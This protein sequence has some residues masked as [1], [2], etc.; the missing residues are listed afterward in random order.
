MSNKMSR[1]LRVIQ[2]S[3]KTGRQPLSRV[4]DGLSAHRK[5]RYKEMYTKI[6]AIVG[7][8]KKKIS[9]GR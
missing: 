5:E 8:T 6:G 2:R 9:M 7:E 3:G 1:S 4:P